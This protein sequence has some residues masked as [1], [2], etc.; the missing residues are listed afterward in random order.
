M[1]K[2][3][4]LQ[5][6]EQVEQLLETTEGKGYKRYSEYK[7]SGVN[8][9]GS[10]PKD[11]VVKS[12]KWES[13]VFRGASPRP[14][15]DPIY[16]DEMGEYAWVRISDVTASGMY[17]NQTSQRL[18]DYGAKLSVKLEPGELFLS[19]A[20]TVGK[21]C[22]TNIRCCIH[23]GFVYFP[24]LTQKSKFLYYVFASGEP[25]KGLGKFGTQLNLNTDTVGSIRVAF[26]SIKEQ[27]SII[28]F[29]DEQTGRIDELIAAKRKLLELLHVKRRAIITHAVTKGLDPDVPMKDS[30]VEW[31]GEV[32]VDWG[33]TR[34][35]RYT[36]W[37]SGEFINNED[38]ETVKTSDHPIPVIG[39]NDIMGWTDTHL[40]EKDTIAVGRVGALCGNVHIV[41][42][43]AWI[44]DN[45][46]RLTWHQSF[47]LHYLA[48]LLEFLNINRFA[49]QTAQPLISG[50]LLRS[51]VVPIPP[52]DE[53]RKIFSYIY[54][55][56]QKINSIV[57]ETEKAISRLN[58][59]RISLISS[60]VTGKIDVRN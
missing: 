20:G 49:E 51:L 50:S 7:D 56:I 45:A 38:V 37:S 31:L 33:I 23:D 42:A 30:G 12:I 53:Q 47:D 48:K 44:S 5:D 11:W 3:D 13:P 18:S 28:R 40:I 22:I 16:F 21:P 15:D 27:E 29:L 25:Y 55:H 52:M 19:I 43:P 41:K 46:L 24:R 59:L 17:L 57:E 26:P 36:K 32:P 39:G 9:L 8:W 58:E 35:G 6:V 2:V 10:V 1:N 14:I 4:A 34:L 60:A 54:S